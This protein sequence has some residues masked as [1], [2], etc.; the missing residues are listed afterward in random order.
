MQEAGLSAVAAGSNLRIRRLSAIAVAAAILLA[1]LLYTPAG[2]LGKADA[3][4]YSVCHRIDL[5]SFHLGERPLPLCSRCLGMY[6]GAVLSVAYFALIGRGRS[7]RFPPVPVMAVLGIF[8]SAFA[9]DGTNS[10]LHFFPQAP[11]LYEPSNVLRLITGSLLG[12]TLGTI[13]YAG[14]NQSAW[15]RWRNRPPLASI[16]EILPLL[17]LAGGMIA[18]VLWENPLILYPLALVSSAGVVLLLTGV[19]TTLVLLVL[20]R[21]NEAEGWRDLVFPLAM[22][23]ALAFAQLGLFAFLRYLAT[24]TWSGFTI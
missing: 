12:L 16:R 24:G 9:I 1:W 8:V 15:R 13:V 19:H 17:S 18:A 6:L 21:E 2:A 7:G 20:R 11:H 23:L 10:Y 5:R 14:F 4:A 3:I 22:G